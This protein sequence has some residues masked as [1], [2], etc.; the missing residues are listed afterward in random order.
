MGKFLHIQQTV[1][2]ILNKTHEEEELASQA[3]ELKSNSEQSKEVLKIIK[4]ISDQT[5]L[6]ALNA[7]M[8]AAR[9]VEARRGFAVVADEVGKLA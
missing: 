8:E 4:E 3:K 7:T 1:N 6:L 2:F 5:E 9:A